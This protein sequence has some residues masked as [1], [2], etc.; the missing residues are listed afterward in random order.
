MSKEKA[1]QWLVRTGTER[2]GKHLGGAGQSA[3]SPLEFSQCF[4]GDSVYFGTIL[5]SS[6]LLCNLNGALQ[7]LLDNSESRNGSLDRCL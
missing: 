2:K 3:S 7:D 6:G 1:I 5:N 4:A